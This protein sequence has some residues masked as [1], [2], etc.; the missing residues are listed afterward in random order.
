VLY[1]FQILPIQL[2]INSFE[3]NLIKYC[4][5]KIKFGALVVDGRGKIG[6][7]VA[8]KNRG[9]AY[10]R[11]KVT[12][13]N[14]NTSAQATV[15]NRLTAFSQGWKG[16][17]AAKRAA[18]NSSVSDYSK[19]DIFGDI[20]QPSGVNLYVK[21][22]SNLDEVGVSAISLPPLPQAVEP[23][24]TISATAA[25]GAPALSVVYTPTPIPADTAFVLRATK[26][27]SPGKTFLKNEFRNIAILDAADTSPEDAL[28]AY[29]AKFGTLVAGQK[30]GVALVPVNKVTGQ[31]GQA[32]TTE[33]I[34]AA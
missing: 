19:T 16:L 12:P 14:P 13:T 24:L 21:L 20:K 22:N 15:R 26:Q 23:V 29:V 3:S 32:I 30:I 17:T 4:I 33:V 2:K 6:G 1:L 11:T 7:H 18:W 8:S 25:A 10:L 9:G 5:M 31:K 28:A 27:V 34:V